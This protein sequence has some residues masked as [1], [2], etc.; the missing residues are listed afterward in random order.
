MIYLVKMFRLCSDNIQTL[1]SQCS[2]CSESVQNFQPMFRICSDFFRIPSTKTGLFRISW[3]CSDAS[4]LKYYWFSCDLIP[5]DKCFID[6]LVT[7]FQNIN[8][9]LILMSPYFQHNIMLLILMGPHANIL[10]YDWFSC[11]LILPYKCV[12]DYHGTSF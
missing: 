9:L 10:K 11:D 8:V 12:I 1:F 4:I 6:S 2:E 5:A 3:L 7:S